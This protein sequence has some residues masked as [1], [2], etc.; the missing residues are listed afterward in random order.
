[1]FL[2]ERHKT[3]RGGGQGGV[4]LFP[5]RLMIGLVAL[6]WRRENHWESSG[7]VMFFPLILFA[8]IYIC[9]L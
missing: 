5:D 8:G 9:R 1:M 6:L 3:K 7:G 2:V 4:L